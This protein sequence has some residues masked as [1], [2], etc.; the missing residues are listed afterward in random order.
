MSAMVG[1]KSS[2]FPGKD[3]WLHPRAGE[4]GRLLPRGCKSQATLWRPSGSKGGC[5]VPYGTRKLGSLVAKLGLTMS[6]GSKFNIRGVASSTL[7]QSGG[8]NAALGLSQC[9]CHP[10]HL[11]TV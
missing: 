5:V 7:V 3:S 1:G 2:P 11:G 10:R 4:K 6:S 9:P 8:R